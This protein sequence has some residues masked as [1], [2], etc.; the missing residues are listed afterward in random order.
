[1]FRSGAGLFS[2]GCLLLVSACDPYER[3][4][5]NDDSLGPV[6]PLNFP[7]ANLGVQ[8]DGSPGNRRLSGLGAFTAVPA[9]AG[10]VEAA[11]FAYPFPPG[12]DATSLRLDAEVPPASTCST[13]LTGAHP[14][15][16]INMI[17]AATR[18]PSIS[19]AT[20]SPSC[21]PPA[22]R[23][24][25]GR[26]RAT[27]LWSREIP[28][29]SPTMGCQ[30]PKS[31]ETLAQ[32]DG[33]TAR[34]PD[35]KFLAFLVIDPG[36]P[37]Y[38][39]GAAADH[40]GVGVQRW[41]WYNRYLLAYLDGGRDPHRAGD[42][43]GGQAARRHHGRA[44][45]SPSAC[46]YPRSLVIGRHGC[47]RGPG[48]AWAPATTSWPPGAEPPGYSPMCEVYTY[49]AGLPLPPGEPARDAA[50]IEM[51]FNTPAAPL[52]PASPPYVFCLQAVTP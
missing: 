33:M 39:A 31:K 51:K 49:D 52:E 26:A 18:S 11:Y 16:A 24:S 45:W 10:G 6:D 20:S 47:R 25:W 7:P 36:S 19:R 15:P 1:M 4:G 50:T 34:E 29:S 32:F 23:P 42:R 43:D 2:I 48:R 8:P 40:P 21:P 13:P 44:A 14:P 5:K 41:G 22:T 28:V 35:G 38:P 37:V 12:S 30:L 27:C 46:T 3:F 17:A 9:F